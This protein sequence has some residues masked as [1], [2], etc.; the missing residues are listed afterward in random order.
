[1]RAAGGAID[2]RIGFAWIRA[3]LYRDPLDRAVRVRF[4]GKGMIGRRFCAI[5]AVRSANG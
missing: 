2:C 3:V 5:L 4:F 1:M